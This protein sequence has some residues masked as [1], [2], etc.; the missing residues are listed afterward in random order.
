MPGLR[1]VRPYPNPLSASIQ[2]KVWDLLYKMDE[3]NEWNN[4]FSVRVGGGDG[5][6]EVAVGKV[7][8]RSAYSLLATQRPVHIPLDMIDLVCVAAAMIAGS[9]V[10]LARVDTDIHTKVFT[11]SDALFD[12]AT[13]SGV[14]SKSVFSLAASGQAANRAITTASGAL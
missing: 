9:Y 2:L 6:D 11:A 5:K 7:L 14:S 13:R 3:W 4:V 10:A 1:V 12:H 8:R